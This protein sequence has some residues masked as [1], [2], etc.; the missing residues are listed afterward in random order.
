SYCR[1]RTPEPGELSKTVSCCLPRN[2]GT[3]SSWLRPSAAEH[4]AHRFDRERN[5]PT[6]HQVSIGKRTTWPGQVQQI[7]RGRLRVTKGSPDVFRSLFRSVAEI[8]LIQERP[9]WHISRNA[10]SVSANS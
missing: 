7:V 4:K 1:N 2:P 6:R 3:N 9:R 10:Q 5:Q 8:D